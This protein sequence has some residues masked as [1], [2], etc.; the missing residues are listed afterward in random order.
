MNPAQK[1]NRNLRDFNSG[2]RAWIVVFHYRE[3]TYTLRVYDES[4]LVEVAR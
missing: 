2:D 4:K 3:A 1:L